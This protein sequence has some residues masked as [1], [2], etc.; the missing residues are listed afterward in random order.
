MSIK[1]PNNVITYTI[2]SSFYDQI[3]LFCDV[4]INGG[5]VVIM[6][7]GVN[8]AYTHGFETSVSN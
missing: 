5:C 8:D 6:T 3:V 1:T 7:S 4:N 2:L